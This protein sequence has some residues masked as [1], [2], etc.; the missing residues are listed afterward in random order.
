LGPDQI[1]YFVQ[2]RVSFALVGSPDGFVDVPA[3]FGSEVQIDGISNEGRTPM[4]FDFRI[5]ID[6][7]E[8]LSVE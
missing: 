8:E 5:T 6:T 2:Q 4:T 3:F 1:F 7:P